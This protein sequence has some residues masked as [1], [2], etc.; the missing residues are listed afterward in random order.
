VV[1]VVE[2]DE[3]EEEEEED[4]DV[5]GADGGVD[6][7]SFESGDKISWAFAIAEES[8]IFEEEP[9]LLSDNVRKTTKS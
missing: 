8:S 4:G 3:E 1:V 6:G 9:A 5:L 7:A 2:E